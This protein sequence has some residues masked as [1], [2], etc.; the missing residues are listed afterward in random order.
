MQVVKDNSGLKSK[1]IESTG[2]HAQQG[3]T[4]MGHLQPQTGPQLA[5]NERSTVSTP[6]LHQFS[7]LASLLVFQSVSA[8]SSDS[9]HLEQRQGTLPGALPSTIGSTE[10]TLGSTGATADSGDVLAS[11]PVTIQ[12]GA[13]FIVGCVVGVILYGMMK[14][15]S[16]LLER[17]IMPRERSR[18][19]E[20]GREMEEAV[21]VE[22]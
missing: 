3:S 6:F 22:V 2:R 13:G 12:L 11:Q 16:R 15:G 1:V 10:G 21:S 7:L 5:H 19:R 14:V 4:H 18:V 17:R 20:R 9:S 8:S